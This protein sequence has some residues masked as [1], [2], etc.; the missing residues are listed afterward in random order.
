MAFKFVVFSC[1]LALAAA[2]GPA[3]YSTL[4]PSGDYGSIGYTQEH[5][6][7]GYGGQNVISSYSKAVDSP[8]SSVRIS[9]SK[10]SNDVLSYG[11][12]APAIGYAAPAVRAVS[13]AAPAVRTVSY[14]APAVRA[15]SYASPAVSYATPSVSYANTYRNYATAPA[16]SYASAAPAASYSSAI[17][18]Q[19]A[20]VVSNAAPA[21][22]AVSNAAPAVSYAAPAA[23]VSYAAA[24][25]MSAAAVATYVSYAVR[26]VSYAA[27][28]VR[29]AS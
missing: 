22:R 24:V 12:A 2:G 21:V 14:A 7:K 10:T 8:H 19:A 6:V 28:A 5:T 29:T 27:P 15:V 9:Q 20:P 1:L 18:T 25:P 13:Y 17:R 11:Y 23:A 4:T 16:L 26:A 3:A